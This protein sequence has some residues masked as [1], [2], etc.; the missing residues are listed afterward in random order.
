MREN[1]IM[2]GCWDVVEKRNISDQQQSVTPSPISKTM[3]ARRLYLAQDTTSV[4]R[5]EEMSVLEYFRLKKSP[6]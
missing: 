5:G 1:S 6:G 4:H 2:Y 3:F